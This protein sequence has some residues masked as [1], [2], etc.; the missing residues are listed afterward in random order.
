MGAGV[1]DN[2]IKAFAA[3]YAAAME[4]VRGKSANPLM[5]VEEILRRY[6]NRI[7]KAKAYEVLKAVRHCCGGGMLNSNSYVML[8]ELEFWEKKVDPTYKE[9]L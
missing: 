1:N 3:G 7:G 2:Y 9:R 4:E 5:G 8:S 6:D